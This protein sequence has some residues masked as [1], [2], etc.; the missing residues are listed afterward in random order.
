M[1]PK[2]SRAEIIHENTTNTD[3]ALAKKSIKRA[4]E[5]AADEPAESKPLPY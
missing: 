2:I 1:S 5:S 3:Q 4:K